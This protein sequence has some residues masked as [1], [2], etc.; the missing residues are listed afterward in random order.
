MSENASSGAWWVPILAFIP[1]AASGLWIAWTQIRDRKDKNKTEGTAREQS[2][3]HDLD[4]QRAAASK[5]ASE[6]FERV[7]LELARRDAE[8][9]RKDTRIDVLE[10]EVNAWI[11]IARGWQTRAFTLQ[12][13]LF[14]ARQELNGLR[15]KGGLSELSWE[16]PVKLPSRL[17]TPE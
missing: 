6:L 1:T 3:M 15:F 13:A 11:A 5:E 14:N 2:L 10:K 9:A 17:D 4:S 7:K 16:E 8:A 12:Y